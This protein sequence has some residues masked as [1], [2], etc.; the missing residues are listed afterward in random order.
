MDTATDRHP[1]PAFCA[2]TLAIHLI[3]AIATAHADGQRLDLDELV[4]HVGARRADVRRTLSALHR[5][6]YLDVLRMRPTL[7]GFALGRAFAG[8]AL[9][10]LRHAPVAVAVARAA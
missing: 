8:Q 3:A 2:D 5:E 4:K 1:H 10:A 6:G 9:P 7:Q